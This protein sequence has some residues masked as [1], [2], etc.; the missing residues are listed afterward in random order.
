MRLSYSFQ[1]GRSAR[2]NAADGC[3]SVLS[4]QGL[5]RAFLGDMRRLVR[6]P[7]P[8]GAVLASSGR[9]RLGCVGGWE[10]GSGHSRWRCSGWSEALV[11]RALGVS[12][13]SWGEGWWLLANACPRCASEWRHL[14]MLSLSRSFPAL[15]GQRV[16]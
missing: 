7:A 2:L 11:H 12:G 15:A 8:L 16:G 4:Q 5:R 6:R 1:G 9:R 10:S 13:R 14:L 3:P